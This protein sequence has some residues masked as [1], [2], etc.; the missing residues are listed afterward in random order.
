MF[1][2]R[3]PREGEEAVTLSQWIRMLVKCS[4]EP[5]AM[6]MKASLG[7]RRVAP[8][9][10]AD[11][12]AHQ[13]SHLPCLVSGA[14]ARSP[15]PPRR[16]VPAE[17]REVP[18]VGM[19]CCFLRAESDDKT[20]VL[21]QEDRDSRATRTQVRSRAKKQSMQHFGEITSLGTRENHPQGRRRA[22]FEGVERT[23]ITTHG[24][25]GSRGPTCRT[26]ARV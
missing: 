16:S 15:N 23:S 3:S 2:G 6:L 8:P 12:E 7:K 9:S 24:W 5:K 10:V 20:T 1:S 14:R 13:A 18:E 17:V 19:D 26:G 4:L 11:G 22:C 21:L 25:R